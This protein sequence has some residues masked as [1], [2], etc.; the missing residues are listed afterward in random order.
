[1]HPSPSHHNSSEPLIG[2]IEGFFGRPWS[3]QARLDHID[4]LAKSGANFYCYAPKSDPYLRRS[5]SCDWPQAQFTQL[6]ELRERCRSQGI[7][8]GLGLSPFGAHAL[9]DEEL[10]TQISRRLQQITALEPDILG[11]F[12]DDMRG[13]T[14][15]LA[16]TQLTCLALA[17]RFAPHCRI[18]F[19]PTYYS[20]DPVLE[21]VFGPMPEGY[22]RAIKDGLPASIDYFWTGEKVCSRDY[23]A[24]HL[25]DVT[26]RLGKKPFIWDNYPVND[27]AVKSQH[28][29]LSEVPESLRQIT[30]MIAGRAI[31]PMNQA[32]L[33][34]YAIS[35]SIAA[36]FNRP[37]IY[38]EFLAN[39]SQ[40]LLSFLEIKREEFATRGLANFDADTRAAYIAQLQ[41]Q[42]HLPAAREIID[43]LSDLYQFDPAC[44]TD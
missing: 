36:H 8:F 34:Q 33:S 21:R 2:T 28:L 20:D 38:T 42:A 10:E 23:S 6:R 31:N 7:K 9:H 43:W 26:T 4:F 13:D 19:C 5:W 11:I 14:P 17:Q 41:P 22:F 24:A 12:F 25:A 32:Y 30:P 3:H 18:I 1:M 40:E 29:Y 35:S 44:L 37:E 39:S 27:G 16:S 15:N